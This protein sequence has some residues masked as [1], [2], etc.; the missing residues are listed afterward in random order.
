M[1]LENEVKALLKKAVMEG[2]RDL[3]EACE[4]LLKKLPKARRRLFA[5]THKKVRR[6][7]PLSE[8]MAEESYDAIF[9]ALA[10]RIMRGPENAI[11]FAYDII[12]TAKESLLRYQAGSIEEDEESALSKIEDQLETALDSIQKALYIM[13]E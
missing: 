4:D 12:N 6:N 7:P 10:Q 5:D 9:H 8:H 3:Q 1:S 2:D 11:E 13:E